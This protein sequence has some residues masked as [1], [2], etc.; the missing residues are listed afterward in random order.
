MTHRKHAGEIDEYELDDGDCLQR[1]DNQEFT[2]YWV[3]YRKLNEDFAQSFAETRQELEG[4]P[5]C[6][7]IMRAEVR[8][9]G[10]V[11]MPNGIGDFF[12]IPPADDAKRV[13]STIMPLLEDWSDVTK[14]IRA[15]AVP[16]QYIESFKAI[17]W[18]LEESRFWMI[19]P[20]EKSNIDF[21]VEWSLQPMARNKIDEIASL[22]TNAFSGG[23]GQYGARDFA[24]HRASVEQY[25]E[26]FDEETVCGRASVL[27]V[28]NATGRLA[29][30]C[31]VDMH[32]NIPAIR[33]VAVEPDYQHQGIAKRLIYGVLN[34]LESQYDWVKLAVT[35]DNPAVTLYRKLGF[36]SGDEL[37]QL[38][39]PVG[40]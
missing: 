10:V 24:A 21:P 35:I 2:K 13:L 9:G 32:K 19:R 37:S 36:I 16:S 34:T 20:T 30:V 7:W 4:V 5:F 6:F 40:K 14:P 31:M 33:L 38:S 12:L 22:L 17:G 11:I 28:E 18:N 3:V 23:V 39:K 27:V 8:I 15:Q 25:F 1:A 26:N 29:G